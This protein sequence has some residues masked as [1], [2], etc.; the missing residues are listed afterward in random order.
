MKKIMLGSV[1]FVLG[2]LALVDGAPARARGDTASAEPPPL[3]QPA[4]DCPRLADICE[5]PGGRFCALFPQT[6]PGTPC[7]CSGERGHA[8]IDD[9]VEY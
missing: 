5:L 6:C 2:A 7:E 1:L 3:A 8:A 4:Q 9:A